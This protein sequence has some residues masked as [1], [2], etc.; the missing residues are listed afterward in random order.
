MASSPTRSGKSSRATSSSPH[1]R[2]RGRAGRGVQSAQLLGEL[3]TAIV[4]PFRA[5]GSVDLDAF[6]ALASHLV[7]H[8]SDGIV[9]A[10]TTGESPTLERR[11]EAGALRGG[12]GR[13]ARPRDR[14]RRHRDVR[15]RALRAPDRARARARRRRVPRR[16]AVLQQAAPA[17]HRGALPGDRRGERQ[18]DR[19]LQHP[20]PRRRQHRARDDRRAR[21]DPVSARRQAG[22]RRPRAGAAHRREHGSRPVRGRRQPGL[23]VPRARRHRRDLRAD[24]HRRR[25][26]EGDDAAVSAQATPRARSASTRS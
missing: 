3:L 19:R 5:D 13:A 8:G 9:V 14:R 25:A 23:P 17:R 15:H 24:A 10:G 21:R 18:A 12:R 2:L 16:H 26:H 20:R 6:R 7:D 1:A 4:T 11:R 22:E